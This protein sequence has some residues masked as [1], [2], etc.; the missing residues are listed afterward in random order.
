MICNTMY[1]KSLYKVFHIGGKMRISW[2]EE[3]K[4]VTMDQVLI[5]L[6]ASEHNRRW[7]PCPVCGAE[8]ENTSSRGPINI[9]RKNRTESTNTD[10]FI[11]NVCHAFGN[12]FELTAQAIF[13]ESAESLRSRGD[14]KSLKDFYVNGG[15]VAEP[16][17]KA[18]PITYPPVDEVRHLLESSLKIDQGTRAHQYLY[19]RGIDPTKIPAYMADPTYDTSHMTKVES[20]FLDKN[21]GEEVVRM[22]SWWYSRWLKAFPILVPMFNFKGDLTSV[23]GRTAYTNYKNRKSTVPIGYSTQNLYMFSPDILK[24][25]H[26]NQIPE[27]VWI[28]EGEIDYLTLTQYGQPTIGIRNCR[29]D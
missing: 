24:W 11:C 9:I 25:L 29:V 6:G 8:S 17:V 13:H 10:K 23:L 26:A 28:A 7:K 18:K 27:K 1:G 14:F 4:N 12:H 20:K 15:F 16:L 19:G 22:I 5:R 21:S 3:A 2:Y